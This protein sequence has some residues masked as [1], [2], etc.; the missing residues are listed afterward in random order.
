M[1]QKQWRKNHREACHFIDLCTYFT[2]SKV[3][4][5]CMNAMGPDPQA[6][7]I[8]ILLNMRMGVML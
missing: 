7:D 6:T 8:T 3:V 5:V 2:G 4:E 1:I